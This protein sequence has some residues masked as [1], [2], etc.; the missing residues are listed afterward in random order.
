M[1]KV[2]K[3]TLSV[4]LVAVLIVSCFVGCG[5]K[6]VQKKVEEIKQPSFV[7]ASDA[8]VIFGKEN[9]T[10]NLTVALPAGNEP[11][12]RIENKIETWNF[13]SS[14]DSVL[15]I[16]LSDSFAKKAEGKDLIVTVEYYDAVKGV[17]DIGYKNVSGE[18]VKQGFSAY[19]SLTQ[20]FVGRNIRL[21]SPKLDAGKDLNLYLTSTQLKIRAIAI[22]IIESI[23]ENPEH[24]FIGARRV[25]TKYSTLTA[26][27]AQASV[28]YF[29]AFGDGKHDDTYAFLTAIDYMNELGSGTLFVPEGK[30]IIK[31]Q[32]IIPTQVCLTGDSPQF[33]GKDKYNEG[34]L[35][36]SYVGKRTKEQEKSEVYAEGTDFIILK[37]DSSVTNLAIF[38]PEQKIKDG[39]AVP[40]SWTITGDS[41]ST[42]E[43]V[44]LV[45]SYYGIRVGTGMNHMQTIR[46]VYGTPL[47]LGMASCGSY[48]ITRYENINFS[49]ECWLASDLDNKPAKKELIN[50]L[51]NN[52]T[53][54]L[55]ERIDWTWFFG[56][57]FDGYNIGM[58]SRQV[59]N[60]YAQDI[61]SGSSSAGGVLYGADIKN[62]NTGILYDAVS[63]MGAEIINS[64]IS[65]TFGKDPVAINIA[66]DFNV[67]MNLTDCYVE[68]SGKYAVFN[69]DQA[70]VTLVNTE[71]NM[72]GKNA[73]YALMMKKL[74]E[75]SVIKSKFSGSGKHIY[76]APN[77]TGASITDTMTKETLLIDNKSKK[78]NIK[79]FYDNISVVTD[80]EIVDYMSVKET[81][82][83]STDFIDMGK[84]PYNLQSDGTMFD[85]SD[86]TDSLREAINAASKNG[87]IVYIPA[88]IYRVSQS[89]TVPSGVE[90]RGVA[91]TALHS[92][93]TGTILVTDYGKDQPNA[94]ALFELNSNSGLSGFQIMYDR[95]K[96]TAI[97]P[98]AYTIRGNGENVYIVN[99]ELINSYQGIDF[100]THRCDNH[101]ISAVTGMVL[102]TGINVGADSKNGIIRDCMFNSTLWIHHTLFD[103]NIYGGWGAVEGDVFTFTQK[104]CEPF[105]IGKTEN[106][107][108]LINFVYGAIYGLK[109]TDGADVKSIGYGS[110]GIRTAVY[111]EGNAKAKL[112]GGQWAIAG[113][114]LGAQIVTDKSFS[115]KLD[116][117]SFVGYGGGSQRGAE[118]YGSGSVN[119]ISGFFMQTT[120]KALAVMARIS[121]ITMIGTTMT[122]KRP[123]TAIALYDEVKNATIY[124]TIVPEKQLFI[125]GASPKLA[126]GDMPAY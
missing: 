77:F 13:S 112:I 124:G 118:L 10:K 33:T 114:N 89:I 73:E 57:K 94:K 21:Q 84:A 69:N 25:N 45:N 81:K 90:I 117:V 65:A 22:N 50:W 80:T 42:I 87:G 27:V 49:K 61:D 19:S 32:L 48:D 11:S 72:T 95:M 28:T 83:V 113:A 62:C 16:D 37:G 101:Y 109:L 100:S 56:L 86:I 26:T 4:I 88:G 59:S 12:I 36:M 51:G 123:T 106:Q 85:V 97:T 115:G 5:K 52:A 8:Y 70:K 7:E 108:L 76:L 64:K 82:P 67:S 40:Y 107:V 116:L 44:V 93:A 91:S 60:E 9:K 96:P 14:K 3:R 125:N 110:D 74:G 105:V 18:E 111:A 79:Y 120:S 71:V 43:N 20:T 68:S 29:G 103:W 35:L 31:E 53:G 1:I 47:Y 2:A 126:K 66:K 98:Y 46:N 92:S 30:Y 63:G 58:H 54:F 17:F 38:Y 34:T 24:T 41:F 119:M 121:N 78:E 55:Y 99:V 39:K 75:L 104:N 122:D 6:E 102:K 23:S 15:E